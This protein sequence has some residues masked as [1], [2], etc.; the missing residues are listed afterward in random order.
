[1]TISVNKK[2]IIS[3]LNDP[4]CYKERWRD[5]KGSESNLHERLEASKESWKDEEAAEKQLGAFE[6]RWGDEEGAQNSLQG[7]LEAS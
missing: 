7:R 4:G 3:R 5:E 6:E 2:I 1:M